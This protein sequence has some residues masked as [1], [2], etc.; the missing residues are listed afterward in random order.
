[1][2]E[3]KFNG[4]GAG[5]PAERR[6][7]VQ[8]QRHILDTILPAFRRQHYYLLERNARARGGLKENLSMD[9]PKMETALV[10]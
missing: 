8:I 3:Q 10:S 2:Q 5:A 1:M 4:G 7:R 9:Y 6:P